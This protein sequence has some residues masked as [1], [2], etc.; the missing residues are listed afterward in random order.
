[1]ENPEDRRVDYAKGRSPST[2]TVNAFAKNFGKT[3]ALKIT[4]ALFLKYLDAPP[5]KSQFPAFQYGKAGTIGAGHKTTL[6]IEEHQ[7]D[8]ETYQVIKA[9]F[10]AVHGKYLYAFGY[11][12]YFD[13]FRKSHWTRFCFRV[14]YKDGDRALPAWDVCGP[15]NDTDDDPAE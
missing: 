11:V 8:W 6:R 10:G 1:M 4:C 14:Y 3:P 9:N 2:I 15:Y 12:T 5:T 13:V 7:F